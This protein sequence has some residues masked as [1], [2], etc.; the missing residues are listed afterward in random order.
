MF[1]K[2]LVELDAPFGG[3]F[4]E[5]NSPARRL[6]FEVQRAIG[7]ALIQAKTA[8]DALVELGK[9]QTWQLGTDGILWVIVR[10]FQWRPTVSLV[11]LAFS[12][13]AVLS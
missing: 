12:V 2:T 9:I 13:E 3:G 6:R 8:M 10:R 5:M 11:S 7:G 4:D 1:F